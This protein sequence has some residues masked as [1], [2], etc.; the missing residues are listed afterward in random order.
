MD[1]HGVPLD[2]VLDQLKIKGMMPDW[3][4]Y[5][6]AARK[7]GWRTERTVRQ[8]AVA[9]GDVYGPD[10]CSAWEERMGVALAASST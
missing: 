9:I 4:D 10:F 5:V 1:T 7:A 3:L 8:L 6:E 2:L